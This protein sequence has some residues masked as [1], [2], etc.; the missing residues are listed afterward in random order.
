M[1]GF[2]FQVDTG[3]VEGDEDGELSADL[4]DESA[5]MS[6]ESESWVLSWNFKFA[7][8]CSI[9][10]LETSVLSGVYRSLKSVGKGCVLG[11]WDIKVNSASFSDSSELE[12]ESSVETVESWLRLASISESAWS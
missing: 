12:I 7:N 3:V 5:E 11:R 2:N 4:K 1:F 6:D 9:G 8:D 10:V